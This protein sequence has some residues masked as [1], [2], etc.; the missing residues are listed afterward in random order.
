MFFILSRDFDNFN[1]IEKYKKYEADYAQRLMA[2]YFSKKNLYGGRYNCYITFIAS[3]IYKF[4][5][6]NEWFAIY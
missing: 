6:V 2:K 4:L 5:S 3:E 1:S